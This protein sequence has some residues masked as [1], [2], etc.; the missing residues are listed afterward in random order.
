LKEATQRETAGVPPEFRLERFDYDLPAAL[1]AQQPSERRDRSRLLV[2][3]SVGPAEHATFADL[4]EYL[5]PGDLLVANDSRVMKAR[6]F[7]KRRGGGAAQ[8]LLLHPAREAGVWEALV[9]PG[10]RIRVGDRLHL[11]RDASIEVVGRTP[12]GT[13]LLRFAG[14]GADEAMAAFGRVPL[15]PYIKGEPPQAEERYQT[16]YAVA[17]GSAAAPTAGLHFTP[18]LIEGLKARQIGWVTLTLHVGAGTFQP[19]RAND[20]RN[21]AMHAERYEIGSE[22]AGAIRQTRASGGR[23]IAVGTTALRALE[24]AAQNSPDGSVEAGNRWTKI[25]I[26]PP[27]EFRV[28][29]GLITNFHL[30]RSSLFMLACAFAGTERISAAYADALRLDYRFYSFGD[31]MLAFRSP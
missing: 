7:A 17:A 2:L 18:E 16:V 23:I 1:I 12:I 29:D 14:I 13:R 20:I 31:A 6:L 26:Y 22:P 11:S 15:P 5:R 9:R 27:F 4:A 3:P 25:F 30:P 10:Q 28:A 24:D 19:V 21:H 8:V